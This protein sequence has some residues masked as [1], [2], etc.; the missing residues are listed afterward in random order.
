MTTIK[1][2]I[3]NRFSLPSLI[4]AAFLTLSGNGFVQ[5]VEQAQSPSEE[6]SLLD[7]YTSSAQDLIL[8]GFE[9]IGINYRFGGTNPE[10]GL[11]CSGFVQVVFRDAMGIL[12]PRSA[13]EQSEVGAVV[14][15]QELKAGDLVF[16]NTMRRAF[17]HVGIYL[18]DNRFMHAPRTGAEVR[19]EDMRQSY[20]LQRYNGA[21]RLLT[22]E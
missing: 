3:N 2:L 9:L 5:A 17:S 19:I 14:D 20:W 10:T 12:L 21:R 7:R 18:G 13:R 22:R 15:R 6:P 11:D 4:T 8:K 16:F 1:R